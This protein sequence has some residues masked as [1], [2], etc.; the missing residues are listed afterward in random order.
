MSF[1]TA[2]TKRITTAALSRITALN[3]SRHFIKPNLTLQLSKIPTLP[4][5]SEAPAPETGH[6]PTLRSFC[7]STAENL[8][9]KMVTER[10][11]ILTAAQ[12]S[13]LQRRDKLSMLKSLAVLPTIHIPFT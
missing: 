11:T 1:G 4:Y 6:I 10:E 5:F 12:F 3:R 2:M 8:P 13:A 9:S 7:F